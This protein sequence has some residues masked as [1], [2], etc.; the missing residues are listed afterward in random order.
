MTLLRTLTDDELIAMVETGQDD[1]TTT[2]LEI[3]LC[4]RLKKTKTEQFDFLSTLESRIE[5][6]QGTLETLS[7]EISTLKEQ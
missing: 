6:L 4:R 1:L 5:T 7:D 2:A 3:E